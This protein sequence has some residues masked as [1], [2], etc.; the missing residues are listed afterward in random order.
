MEVRLE[1]LVLVPRMASGLLLVVGRPKLLLLLSVRD[2][3]VDGGHLEIDPLE[4]F[5][6]LVQTRCVNLALELDL[7]RN[8]KQLRDVRL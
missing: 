6:E 4:I 8:L 2:L 1:L 5:Y 7:V 3:A